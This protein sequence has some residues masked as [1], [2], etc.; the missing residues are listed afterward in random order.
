MNLNDMAEHLD[1]PIKSPVYRELLPFADKIRIQHENILEAAS[2]RQDFT[3][4][5]SRAENSPDSHLRLCGTY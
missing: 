1:S 4:I 5:F 3:A 2:V